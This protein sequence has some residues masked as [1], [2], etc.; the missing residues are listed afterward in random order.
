MQ[1]NAF[2]QPAWTRQGT[3]PSVL[4]EGTETVRLRLSSMT[5]GPNSSSGSLVS[6][7]T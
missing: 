3:A 6:Y 7:V 5:A 2:M 4:H 1:L